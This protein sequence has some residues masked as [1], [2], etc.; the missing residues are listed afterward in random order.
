MLWALL[1][2]PS[3]MKA[4][5][6]RQ[7]VRDI[8]GMSGQQLADS[9]PLLDDNVLVGIGSGGPGFN[10]YRPNELEYLIALVRSLKQKREAERR[11][12]LTDYDAFLEWIE[13]VPRKGTRKPLLAS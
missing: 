3:N 4:R 7:Q 11:R 12:I 5:T 6:K 13:S 2:F 8:W 1:L 9:N 10:N